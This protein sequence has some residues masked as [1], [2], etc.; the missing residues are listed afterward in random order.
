MFF[1]RGPV[2]NGRVDVEVWR[3]AGNGGK[4]NSWGEYEDTPE[5]PP[6]PALYG[7][8]KSHTIYGCVMEPRTTRE[9]VK[10]GYNEITTL[11]GITLFM[12]VNS[13]ISPDDFLAFVSH[14]G[15][16][17]VFKL[18]GEGSVNNYVSPHTGIIGGREVFATRLRGGK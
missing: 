12:G 14:S 2:S 1:E 16:Y 5:P 9:E 15:Q 18:E 3:R 10:P 8:K 11:T 13:D 7:R 17:E 6:V 4:P